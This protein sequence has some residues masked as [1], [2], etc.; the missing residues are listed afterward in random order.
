MKLTPGRYVYEVPAHS[1][2]LSVAIDDRESFGPLYALQHVDVAVIESKLHAMSDAD[3]VREMPRYFA[4][5]GEA[6][7]VCPRPDKP[8]NLVGHYTPPVQTF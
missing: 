4:V 1:Q 6:L 2:V 7:I 8:Y 3:A 5:A